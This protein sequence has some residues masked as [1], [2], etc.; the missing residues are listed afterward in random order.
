MDNSSLPASDDAMV[1]IGAGLTGATAAA[2]LRE[3]GF[4]GPVVLVGAEGQAPY[5]RPPL[6]KGF[7]AGKESE[8]SLLPY[9]EKW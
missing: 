7:L 5:L 2:T 1:I 9:P 3:E 8:E 4:T 6:S